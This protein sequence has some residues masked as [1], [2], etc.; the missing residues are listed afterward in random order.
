MVSPHA[1]ERASI[2]KQ[3]QERTSLSIAQRKAAMESIFDP[4]AGETEPGRFQNLI[5]VPKLFCIDKEAVKPSCLCCFCDFGAQPRVWAR[6]GVV[7]LAGF[8][9]MLTIGDTAKLVSQ[10]WRLWPI[11]VW[12]QK[13][14]DWLVGFKTRHGRQMW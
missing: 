2:A 10:P 5:L 6:F 13:R 14:T 9:A 8:L 7:L 12:R 1:A 11:M 3:L 4:E